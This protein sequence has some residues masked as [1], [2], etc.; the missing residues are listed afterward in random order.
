MTF[1]DG[2]TQSFNER[3]YLKDVFESEFLK[4]IWYIILLLLNFIFIKWQQKKNSKVTQLS[5]SSLI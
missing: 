2:F 1:Y 4:N 3:I 5:I